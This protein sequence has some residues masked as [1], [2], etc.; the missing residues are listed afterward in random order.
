MEQLPRDAAE[1][2]R[3]AAADEPEAER[4]RVDG[5]DVRDVRTQ[6]LSAVLARVCGGVLASFSSRHV[7]QSMNLLN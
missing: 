7:V 4:E 5:W 3:G 1:A 2:P 6:T